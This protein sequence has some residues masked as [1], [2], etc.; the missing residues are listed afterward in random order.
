MS[1]LEAL[2]QLT[3]SGVTF[4]M[5]Y[6]GGRVLGYDLPWPGIVIGCVI[7]AILTQTITGIHRARLARVL[8]QLHASETPDG[9]EMGETIQIEPGV[10][11]RPSSLAERARP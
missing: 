9:E 8:A 4:V 11:S 7:G 1:L 10:L 3:M 2:D 6:S 5:V